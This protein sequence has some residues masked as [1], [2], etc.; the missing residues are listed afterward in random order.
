MLIK[1]KETG[2][3][4]T[5]NFDF[6]YGEKNNACM[7]E[8]FVC[9]YIKNKFRYIHSYRYICIYTYYS[10]WSHMPNMSIWGN[11]LELEVT[12]IQ[13]QIKAKNSLMVCPAHPWGQSLLHEF[14]GLDSITVFFPISLFYL[15]FYPFER[16][17]GRRG[18]R[19][20]GK[21]EGEEREKHPFLL[22]HLFTYS[23]VDSE[24]ES[25]PQPWCIGW[26]SNR[27]GINLVF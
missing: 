25:N 14:H 20:G 1:L 17:R 16:E 13:I 4:I 15:F 27:L 7:Y 10:I 12:N 23:L 9:V 24:R 26:R 11:N 5:F 19:E 3:L 21:K 18:G 22:F 2:D 8:G 6:I